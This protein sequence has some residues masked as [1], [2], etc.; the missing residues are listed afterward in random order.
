MPDE[1]PNDLMSA[2]SLKALRRIREEIEA[3][4]ERELL[5]SLGVSNFLKGPIDG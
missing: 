3:K 4:E 1:S 2:D 5:E